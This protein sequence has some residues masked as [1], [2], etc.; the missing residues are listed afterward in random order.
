MTT[1]S[2]GLIFQNKLYYEE[3]LDK[4]WSPNLHL[5]DK[6]SQKSEDSQAMIR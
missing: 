6:S 5:D 4:S 1:N 2:I 3:K